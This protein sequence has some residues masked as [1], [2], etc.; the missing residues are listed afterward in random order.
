MKKAK[1]IKKRQKVKSWRKWF[2]V[3]GA[4][5][6][7]LLA[8]VVNYLYK[9]EKELDEIA[10]S[11]SRCEPL[12]TPVYPPVF[13]IPPDPNEIITWTSPVG[14]GAVS[15]Q[16]KLSEVIALMQNSPV[17]IAKE[18]GSYLV[19]TH[20]PIY[21]VSDDLSGGMSTV[22][23]NEFEAVA[24]LVNDSYIYEATPF[25]IALNLVYNKELFHSYFAVLAGISSEVDPAKMPSGTPVTPA[26][27]LDTIYDCANLRASAL[28]I[29]LFYQL[30]LYL[31]GIPPQPEYR[32]H[33]DAVQLLLNERWDWQSLKWFNYV[34]NNLS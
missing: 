12:A 20:T 17:P 25:D 14:L 4:A 34:E 27:L 10:N 26:E 18:T 13:A 1:T 22:F 24:I 29:A 7:V 19:N 15:S 30:G 16:D 8:V 28:Q 31:P 11:I 33:F 3:I 9:L 2:W 6:L 23:H 32:A 5:F 21:V